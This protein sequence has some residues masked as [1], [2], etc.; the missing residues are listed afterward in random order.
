MDQ[1]LAQ[2]S[3]FFHFNSA[4]NTCDQN[5]ALCL[6]GF[7][8]NLLHFAE[9]LQCSSGL[10]FALAGEPGVF[11]AALIQAGIGFHQMACLMHTNTCH[12]VGVTQLGLDEALLGSKCAD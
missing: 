7:R 3:A 4:I 8:K 1:N 6:V 12:Q 2:Q 5:N 10:H 9:K 11:V